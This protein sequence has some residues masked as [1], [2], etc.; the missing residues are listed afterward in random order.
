L[1]H[2]RCCTGGAGRAVAGRKDA[3]WKR[4]PTL[5]HPERG[6]DRTAFALVP[7]A[8]REIGKFDR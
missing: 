2:G 7:Q 1:L 5:C 4:H 8:A 6:L 3:G